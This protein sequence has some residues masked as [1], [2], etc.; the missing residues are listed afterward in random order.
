MKFVGS[1]RG[2]FRCCQNLDYRGSNGG[3]EDEWGIDRTF[4]WFN[5]GT[6]PDFVY[7]GEWRVLG[8][9]GEWL[10]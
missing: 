7:R 2:S 10:L 5:R 4:P 8:C 3:K 6:T 1:R 9:Y